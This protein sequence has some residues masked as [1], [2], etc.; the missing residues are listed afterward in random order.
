MLFLSK[1]GIEIGPILAGAGILG[2]AVGFGSQELVRDII[3]G[4]FIL[5]EN[6]VRIDDIA[7]INT[8]TGTVEKIELRTL[9]LRD[10]SGTIHVFQN[11]KISTLSNQTKDWSAT[12]LEIGVSYKEDVASVI[13]IMKSVFN[14]L[15]QDKSFSDR[16]IEEI[17]IM[18]LDR[19]DNS[20]VV[21]KARIKTLPGEQWSTKRQ[22]QNKLK[23]EF[24]KEGI[25][26]PFPHST[27]FFGEKSPPLKIKMENPN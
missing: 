3:S 19:F 21:I 8:V 7:T 15:Q 14:E 24:E 6:Q 5:L 23:L 2:L 27:L 12:V 16:V 10:P 26:I 25:E 11:G 18:G 4:F 13:L 9:T 1:V 20:A 17:E 22:Y